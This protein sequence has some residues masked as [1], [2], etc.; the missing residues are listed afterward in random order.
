M[1]I[2]KDRVVSYEMLQLPV[3]AILALKFTSDHVVVLLAGNRV[4]YA[5]NKNKELV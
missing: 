2:K 4:L 5:I 1:T 3:K